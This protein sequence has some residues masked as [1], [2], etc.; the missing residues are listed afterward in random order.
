MRVLVGDLS[1][2]RFAPYPAVPPAQAED[3]PVDEMR[4][5]RAE[6][7]PLLR[8]ELARAPRRLPGVIAALRRAAAEHGA[9]ALGTVLQGLLLES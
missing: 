7:A 3:G 5:L 6:L 9:G 8:R 1:Y 4:I 2:T